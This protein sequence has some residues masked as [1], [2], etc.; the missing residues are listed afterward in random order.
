M[1]GPH[2]SQRIPKVGSFERARTEAGLAR[3]ESLKALR[4]KF[5]MAAL[6]GVIVRHHHGSDA[7][8]CRRAYAIADAMLKERAK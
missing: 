5:A 7:V 3:R 1:F 6:S 4:D 2:S 8:I